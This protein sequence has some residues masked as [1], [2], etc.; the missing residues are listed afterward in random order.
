MADLQRLNDEIRFRLQSQYGE[1]TV[2][3][4]QLAGDFGVICHDVN[5]RLRRCGEH[6]KQGLRSEAILV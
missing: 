3:L 1:L 6:L 2:D 4:K 5:G